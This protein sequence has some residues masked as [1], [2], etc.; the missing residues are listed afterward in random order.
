MSQNPSSVDVE[1]ASTGNEPSVEKVTGVEPIND[2][3][4][5]EESDTYD[6]FDHEVCVPHTTLNR[7]L[8]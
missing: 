3:D 7:S 4:E 2:D 1:E 8:T 5:G 6:D